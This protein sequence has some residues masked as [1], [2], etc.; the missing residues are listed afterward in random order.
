MKQFEYILE[1]Y[2]T[3]D[4]Q[5]L[6]AFLN[7]MGEQGWELVRAEYFTMFNNYECIFK[8]EKSFESLRPKILRASIVRKEKRGPPTTE[9]DLGPDDRGLN[10][11]C[12]QR[13]GET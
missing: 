8:R 6:L 10:D 7:K 9:I 5:V 3:L 12:G 11:M 2:D 1:T 4:N 13:F